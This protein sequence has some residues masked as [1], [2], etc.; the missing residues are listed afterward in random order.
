MQIFS[1]KRRQAALAATIALASSWALYPSEAEGRS[2]GSS[3]RNSYHNAPSVR[4]QPAPTRRF[5]FAPRPQ[6]GGFPHGRSQGSWPKWY[7]PSQQPDHRGGQY[8]YPQRD[9]RQ[10]PYQGWQGG[11]SSNRTWGSSDHAIPHAP[12]PAIDYRSPFQ[13]HHDGRGPQG[14]GKTGG[15]VPY[16]SPGGGYSPG[17]YQGRGERGQDYGRGVDRK[18]PWPFVPS[19]H[20]DS[21]NNHSGYDGDRGGYYYP[22]AG[23]AAGL[24]VLGI[25]IGASAASG[26]LYSPP[27]DAYS[28]NPCVDGYGQPLP[29]SDPRYAAN[30][31]WNYY[32]GS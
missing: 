22:G 1:N 31:C 23:A 6:Q 25:T 12:P 19:R 16:Q 26:A 5:F 29:P 17:P 20:G 28:Q 2:Q 24:T 14:G 18:A 8:G 3:A 21:Y 7:T 4:S 11:N 27:A 10:V 30:E 32:F 9:W 13:P 15:Y